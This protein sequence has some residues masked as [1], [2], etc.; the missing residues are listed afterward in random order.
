MTRAEQT[1]GAAI[2]GTHASPTLWLGALRR[3]GAERFHALGLPTTRMEEWRYTSLAGLAPLELRPADRRAALG[4][5]ELFELAERPQGHRLVFVNGR[6]RPE[7]SS[8]AALPGGAYAGSLARVLAERPGLVEPHLGRLADVKSDA[9]A[10]LNTALLE[11]GAVVHVPDGV[12][13]AEEIEL[14]FLTADGTGPVVTH[15]RVLVVAGA[16]AE[17]TV[18][19]S[20]LGLC[21][22]PSLTAAVTEVAVGE[23]ARVDHYKLQ[24]EPERT[25]HVGVLAS[26]QGR[27]GRFSTHQTSLGGR[28]SRSEVR[29]VLD[30]EGGE[31]RLNGLYMASGDQL[32]DNHS[33]IEHARAGCVSRETY[34]GILDGRARGVFGGR[35]RVLEGAQKTDAYQVNSNLLLSED[36]EVDT[37]PQLEIFA[38]DVK[39]GHG[40]TVGQLDEDALFY[41]RSRGIDREAARSLLTYAFASE[42]VGMVR[43]QALRRRI[44]RL[45]AARLPEGERL[46]EAA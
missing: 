42:M 26:R 7:L 11:D 19:E 46:R 22:G 10:A 37:K 8:Q 31:A 17:V 41:L 25:F 6:W 23:G 36:A 35:I 33:L 18:V 38:D 3:A 1:L 39:C 15:P 12:V 44:G 45:V 40:G 2:E 32:V 34:K 14:L 29:A 30:G 9:F 20:Y 24:D 28:L 5:E 16:R 21:A 27:G 13:L 4:L 43:P